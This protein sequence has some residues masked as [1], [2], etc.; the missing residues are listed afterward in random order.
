LAAL[1]AAGNKADDALEDDALLYLLQ[2]RDEYG[3]WMSGQATVRVLKALLPV[4][5]RQLQ[6]PAT[7]NFALKVN[8]KPLSEELAG[9]LKVDSKLLDAPRSI[10]LSAMIH[11]GTNTLEFAG[12]TNATFANAQITAW[13]YVPWA[14]NAAAKTETTVPGKSFGLDFGY[15]CDAVNA[16]V[17]QPINCTVSARRFGSE[18]YGMMLA[19]VGL[20]PGADVDR[21]SLGKLLDN[22][23]ISRYELQPDRIVFYLW[24]SAAEGDKFT[25][26][27]TPRYSIRAKAAP[28]KLVD[29]YN[30][31]LRA[32]IAPQYFD[33]GSMP[34]Q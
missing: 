4:A 18:G 24:S 8:G 26:R 17:G 16:T 13:L 34:H 2:N 7:A 19:E 25:F 3:V 32:V 31:D 9:A 33:V 20:P 6:G 14:Q 21:V 27:F 12:T 15:T 1:Q 5:L 30:P 10:D 23:S 28:A 29:Y 11:G 22:W